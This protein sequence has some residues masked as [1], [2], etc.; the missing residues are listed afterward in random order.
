MWNNRSVYMV[1][2]KYSPRYLA[3]GTINPRWRLLISKL[4]VVLLVNEIHKLNNA[5]NIHMNC[6]QAISIIEFI[7]HPYLHLTRTS[8][9]DIHTNIKSQ[10][11]VCGKK[12]YKGA[13]QRPNAI[14]DLK[15]RQIKIRYWSITRHQDNYKYICTS[16]S[17]NNENTPAG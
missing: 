14:C 11:C 7:G 13:W 6:Q 1:I 9:T 10:G 2:M 16:R 15:I 17:K 8:S 3:V 5:T 4:K 12:E